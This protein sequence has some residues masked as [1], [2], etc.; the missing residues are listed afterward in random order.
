MATSVPHAIGEL[1]AA[2]QGEVAIHLGG[3]QRRKREGD[4]PPF[5]VGL[6]QP[7]QVAGLRAMGGDGVGAAAS[8]S[9]WRATRSSAARSRHLADRT[10]RRLPS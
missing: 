10:T 4:V 3:P 9:H 5:G 8:R 1:L 6:E 7:D 2:P